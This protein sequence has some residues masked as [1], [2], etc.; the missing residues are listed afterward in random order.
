MKKSLLFLSTALFIVS[1]GQKHIDGVTIN[2]DEAVD[3]QFEDVTE[4]V[5]VVPLVSD[6][7][8]GGC[9]M[10]QCYGDELFMVDELYHNVYYFKDNKLEGVLKAVGRGR[11]EYTMIRKIGYD[12]ENKILYLVPNTDLN[13]IMCYSVPKMEYLETIK[14]PYQIGALRVYD[15]KTLLL[16]LKNEE[17]LG[18]YLFDVK[19]QDIIRKVCNLTSFQYNNSDVEIESYSRKNGIITLFDETNYLCEITEDSLGVLKEYN[20][21][22]DGAETEFYS[23]DVNVYL[24]YLFEYPDKYRGLYYPHYGKTGTSFWYSTLLKKEVDYRFYRETKSGVTHLKGF[25]IP[26]LKYAMIPKCITDKG[27]ITLI[28]GDVESFI[29]ETVD[30]SPLAKEIIKAVRKQKDDNPVLVYYEMK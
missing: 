30:P 5:K 4:N 16:A 7:P 27:F 20:Y 12:S 23:G 10:L 3:V 9:S 11:G 2:P 14:A 15:K 19:T 21:G 1:C 24:S 22:R 13:S 18:F 17:D 26:G 29:D 25:H 28:S 8:L 6:D